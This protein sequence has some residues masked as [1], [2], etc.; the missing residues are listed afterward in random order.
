MQQQ[1]PNEDTGYMPDQD[2]AV[3]ASQPLTPVQFM[4]HAAAHHAGP[5][6]MSQTSVLH[7]VGVPKQALSAPGSAPTGV[8]ATSFSSKLSPSLLQINATSQQDVYSNAVQGRSQGTFIS[9]PAGM[10]HHAKSGTTTSRQLGAARANG[11]EAGPVGIFSTRAAMLPLPKPTTA[12]QESVPHSVP[13]RL[14]AMMP[15]PAEVEVPIDPEALER[16]YQRVP[17]FGAAELHADALMG[18]A[19]GMGLAPEQPERNLLFF[20][21]QLQQL[22]SHAQEIG[23]ASQPLAAALTARAAPPVQSAPPMHAAVDLPAHKHATSMGLA[24]GDVHARHLANAHAPAG[25]ATTHASAHGPERIVPPGVSAATAVKAAA[26]SAA[27]SRASAWGCMEPPQEVQ[28]A[29]HAAGLAL[30]DVD[31]RTMAG[32]HEGQ[33]ASLCTLASEAVHASEAV[34]QAQEGHICC[35]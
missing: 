26:V 15:Y 27:A 6:Q 16:E 14:P 22:R 23:I 20:T 28:D 1:Q 33:G 8:L 13:A 24:M 31:Y 4:G 9:H 12:S 35:C 18:H 25:P 29:L 5:P 32:G 3:Q 19:A 34:R 7:H 17:K 10:A 30:T 21:Q 11:Q 2:S